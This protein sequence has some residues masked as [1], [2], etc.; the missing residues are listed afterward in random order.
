MKLLFYTDTEAFG[1]AERFLQDLLS[2]LAGQGA[3]IKLI[4]AEPRVFSRIAGLNGLQI[5][6]CRIKGFFDLKGAFRLLKL[7][8]QAGAD[9]VHFNLT[10]PYSCQYAALMLRFGLPGCR[11][12]GTVHMSAVPGS[13]YPLIGPA[14][15]WI[16]W[17][18]LRVL[19]TCVCPSKAAAAFLIDR[20]GVSSSKVRMIYNG[21][22]AVVVDQAKGREIEQRYGL[23]G[24]RPV[25]CIS[26]LVKGKGLDVLLK[27]FKDVASQVRN[28]VLLIV[29]DGYLLAELKAL[30]GQLGLAEQ[31]IFT[32]HQRSVD[33]CLQVAEVSVTAS[34]NESLPY[35]VLEAMAYGKAIVATAVGGVPEMIDQDSGILV[36]PG[37]TKALAAALIKSL[38]EK[39]LAEKLAAQA[40]ARAEQFF[41][42]TRM[43]DGYGSLLAEASSCA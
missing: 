6:G 3:D 11:A 27:A 8:R 42:S 9:V 32:G 15:R 35:S 36:P 14:R 29:G 28:A 24:K 37:D 43:C 10:S 13:R 31:I 17:N 18:T 20:Y 19:A 33:G 4:C 30:A 38:S 23:A 25:V 41:S 12:I 39:P 26:R 1:G 22:P 21:I 34:L 5:I 2:G 7:F 40:R 16:A